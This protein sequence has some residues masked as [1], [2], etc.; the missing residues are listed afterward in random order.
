[1]K[2][3]IRYREESG[4]W[5]CSMIFNHNSKRI[6]LHLGMFASKEDAEKSFNYAKLSY[7]ISCTVFMSI[8]ACK[9]GRIELRNEINSVIA[10]VNA[11][12]IGLAHIKSKRTLSQSLDLL[13]NTLNN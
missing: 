4:K 5:Q 11:I 12:N 6:N 3:T 8:I 2:S 9:L 10:Q 7:E 13:H 1:M